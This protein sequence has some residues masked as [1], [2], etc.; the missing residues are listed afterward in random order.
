MPA[1]DESTL[2]HFTA[3]VQR[4]I[5]GKSEGG[6]FGAPGAEPL[7]TPSKKQCI[8]TAYHTSCQVWYTLANGIINE[9]YYPHVDRPNTRDLQFLI[10]DG[11]TFIHE[12][13]RDLD[14]AIEYPEQNTLLARLINSDPDGRYRLVKEVLCDPHHSVLLMHTR[15]EIFD[16]SLEGKLR[17]FA[18]LA[19]HLNQCGSH[20][21]ASINDTGGRALFHM[22]RADAADDPNSADLHMALGA[23]PD[24]LRRSCGYVGA[25]DG[26]QDLQNFAMDWTFPT[27]FDGNIAVTG[28]CDISRGEFILALGFGRSPQGGAT[29]VLQAFAT[30]FSKHRASFIEDWHGVCSGPAFE[31]FTGD[32]GDLF[33]ISRC[34]LHTH[35]DKV[36]CGAIVASMS[37]PWGETKGDKDIGGYH[38]VWPRDL[39][40][41][42]TGLLAA[43]HTDA[44]SRALVWLACLQEKNGELP[45]NSWISGEAFWT[46]QQLDEVAAP[47]LLAWRVREAKALAEFDPWLAICRAC[48][49]LIANGPVTMQERWEECSGYSPATIASSIAAMVISAEFARE[50]GDHVTADFALSYADWLEAHLEKWTVTTC[51]DL[52]PGKPKHFIRITP[53]PANDPCVQAAPDTA[54]LKI[55]NG[56]GEHPARNVV[57]LDFLQLVRLGVRDANDPLIVESVAVTDAVLRHDLP[58]G[59]SWRRYNHDG[60]GQHKDGKPFDGTGNGGCWP[61][62]TGERGHYELAAGRDPMSYIKAMEKLTNDGRMLPEQVWWNDD[63]PGYKRG[64]PTG[65]A[66]PLCWAHAEYMSLVRSASDAALFGLIKPVHDRYVSSRPSSTHQMWSLV[67]QVGV[68]PSGK[69]LRVIT[70]GPAIVRYSFNDSLDAAGEITT[71]STA[72]GC[73]YADLPS[74]PLSLGSNITF[75]ILTDSEQDGKA[76][77]IEVIA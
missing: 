53:A 50:R 46:G 2:H 66:M 70:K 34:L 62:L 48:G 73:S 52:V 77:Q 37:I 55:V 28:E 71:E 59:P 3:Q 58:Q 40:Q 29:K 61:L 64:E 23:E 17:I 6:A 65:S 5:L 26:W 18:L 10:T 33:R 22:W 35:E 24:F 51:G 57:G 36:F 4:M 12:E 11:E 42:C 19:P 49:Y 47:V 21:S 25:S 20:N 43:G 60:Y 27:A 72:L 75:N 14:H 44:P 7:W 69:T 67:H 9:V 31:K 63:I 32:K 41:S 1:G 30:P 8:G 38:L 45:Q 74:Q 39:M 68:M 76:H 15:V 16:K 56:G 13:Q 54:V